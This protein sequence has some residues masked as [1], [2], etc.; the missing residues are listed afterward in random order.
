[1]FLRHNYQEDMN[2]AIEQLAPAR[3]KVST[4]EI[5]RLTVETNE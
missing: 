5:N 4:S 3:W 2:D 1:L